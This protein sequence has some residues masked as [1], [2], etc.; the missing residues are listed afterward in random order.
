MGYFGLTY[1][2]PPTD[3]NPFLVFSLPGIVGA[4]LGYAAPFMENRFATIV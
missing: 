1:N 4:V 2:T 3:I